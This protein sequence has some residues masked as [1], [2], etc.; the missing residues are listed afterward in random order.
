ML[1]LGIVKKLQKATISFVMSVR[2]SLSLC[3]KQL[4]SHW[5]DFHEIWY[6]SIFQKSMEKIEVS[7]KLDT[8]IM[9]SLH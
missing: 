6:L 9:G 2:L 7:L 1:I 8:K 4:T 5:V 3:M